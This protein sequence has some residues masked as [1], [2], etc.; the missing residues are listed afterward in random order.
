MLARVDESALGGC[1]LEL[2]PRRSRSLLSRIVM[3]LQDYAEYRR[4]RRAL[5]ALD[6]H[7]LKDIGLSRAEASRLSEKGYDW[8]RGQTRYY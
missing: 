4:Q 1:A 3:T 6:D 2:R 7:M 5:M 8:S